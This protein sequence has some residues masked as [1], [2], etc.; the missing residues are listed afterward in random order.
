MQS[1]QRCTAPLFLSQRTIRT[2]FLANRGPLPG[3]TCIEV[4]TMILS[5]I[6]RFLRTW[7][8]YNQSVN[9]L[10]RLSDRELADIGIS[11]GDIPAAAWEASQAV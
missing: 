5:S 10:S 8:R 9:E 7:R 6:V 2:Y 1:A 11:R 3:P 4:R